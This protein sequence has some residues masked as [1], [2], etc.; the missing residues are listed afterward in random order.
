LK[1]QRLKNTIFSFV[2]A[3]EESRKRLTESF[4]LIFE[5]VLRGRQL[6]G[7]G[8]NE[9]GLLSIRVRDS[10]TNR[11]FDLDGMSSGEKGLILIFLT[12][13]HSLAARGIVLLDEPELH[14]NPAVCRDLLAFFAES[15]AKRRHL[16]FIFCSHSPEILAGALERDDCSLYHLLSDRMVTKV[17][18][19][20]KE[21][22]SEAL[23]RLGTS[24]I[25]GL[26]YKATLFVEGPDDVTILEAGFGDLL[27]R[28]K[29]K[30][31]G[32]RKEVEKQISLLQEAELPG[33]PLSPRYF[34]FDK[35][36]APTTLKSSTNVKIKQWSRRCLENFLLDIDV[37]ADLLMNEE[38][39]KTPLKNQGEVTKLLREL[40]L[41]Q[42]DEYVARQIFTGYKYSD[43]GL[44]SEDV[45]GG[46]I[47]TM[48][49]LAFSRIAT[50]QAQISKLTEAEWISDFIARCE[51]LKSILRTKWET[52][53]Q[54]DCDGKKLFGDLHQTIVFRMP[55]RRFK[56]RV[57]TYM[58]L[59]SSEGWRT[60][61]SVL[62]E[63]LSS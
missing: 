56:T 61:E 39:V 28:H 42:L 11:E 29:V 52:T 58:R 6:I 21:N 41:S 31:L 32:G 46:S 59:N 44:R 38:I 13:E 25:D 60:V 26:L 17:R 62:K 36:D 33:D 14:L 18:I 47:A 63:L 51:E 19:G 23:R 49:S 24:E 35:D 1:Y 43:Y 27:R 53:W 9:I 2:V 10:D 37:L 30:D 16:Q 22:V 20:Q 5:K 50:S 12:L 7:C 4:Q 3:S 15:Y 40:A 57:I 55:L 45:S 54:S 34:I 8:V 48:A